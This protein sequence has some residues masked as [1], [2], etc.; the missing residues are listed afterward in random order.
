MN[1]HDWAS[2]KRDPDILSCA[3]DEAVSQIIRCSGRWMRAY[4]AELTA[5]AKQPDYM[6]TRARARDEMTRRANLDK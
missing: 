1:I 2:A 3:G 5:G 6:N 4:E